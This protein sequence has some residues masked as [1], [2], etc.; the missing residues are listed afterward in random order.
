[1]LK[2]SFLFV[3]ALAALAQAPYRAPRGADGHPDL[4]GIWQALDGPNWN[5]EPHAAGAGA[6]AQLGAAIAVPPGRGIV[7]GG[8]IPYLPAALEKRQRNFA[9]R[10]KLDPEIKCY[11]PGVP[12]A[13]YI[14]HPFQIVQSKE[15][16]LLSYQFAGAVRQIH[17]GAPKKAPIDQW[18][19]WS[20]GRW[21]GDTLVVDVTGMNGDTWFD[22]AG[23]HHSEALHVVER[24]T[25]R[26]AGVLWYEAAIEDPKTFSQ[27]WKIAL[28]LYRRAEPGARIMEFKCAEFAEDALYGH[29][30]KGAQ[31]K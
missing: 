28:P 1:M 23:N 22:R 13:T 30:R 6:V 31:S 18:M 14:G 20:N 15:V 24:Y 11:M 8:R 26:S 19:G 3:M 9:D 2:Q 17:M 4:S 5:I 25:P 27:P 10:L 12:R 21:E 7:E 16:I 29:L